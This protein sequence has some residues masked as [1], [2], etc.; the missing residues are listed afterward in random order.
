MDP[1][2]LQESG[3]QV[4]SGNELLFKGALEAGVALMTGYPG[5]PVADFFDGAQAVKDWLNER[6]IVV[7]LAHNEAL[8]V[9]RVNGAQMGNIRA[10]A[11]MK[12]VGAHVASD[13]MA[14]GNLAK[15]G[16]RGGAVVI[17]GDDP[18]SDSTQVP[19]DSRFLSQH[20]HL[21]VMEPATFQ[22]LK[23]W[24]AVAFELS[25]EADC[26]IGY[27]VTTNQADGGGSVEARANRVPAVSRTQRVTLDAGAIPVEDTVLLPPRTGRREAGL[28][29]RMDILLRRAREL[30]VNGILR[31]PTATARVG[32]VTSGLAYCYLEHAL[33][34][35]GVSGRLPILKLGITHPVDATLV[36]E[37][38]ETV[39]ALI[40]VE[41]KR[42]FLETQVTR[43]LKDAFQNGQLPRYISVW[44]KTFPGGRPG[45]PE[46]GGL[47]PSL[48]IE[49]LAP[50]LGLPAFGVEGVDPQRLAAEATLVEATARY[51]VTIP[52]RMPTFCPGC[53]H[54]DSSSVLLDLK[55]DFLNPQYM[56][57][58]HGRGPVDLIFHGD[59]GCYTMYMFEPTKELMH[60]Y[61][62]MGLGGG[63]GAGIDPFITNKQIVFMGDSTFYHSGMLAISDSIQHKQDA[64]Y[65]ILDNKTTAMTGHQP[66]PGQDADIVGRPTFPQ[67]IEAIVTGMTRGG[68][69]PVVRINPAS[70]TGYR[71]CLED[72][73]LQDG[74]KVIIADKECGITY[75]RRVNRER[76]QELNREGFFREELHINID[77]EVCEFC[78]EC[79]RAT[80]CPGLAF[81]DTD[82][83][84]KV[85]IDNSICVE[86]TACSKRKVCPSFEE[87]RVFRRQAPPQKAWPDGR[88]L[89]VPRP[90][91]F[92]ETWSAYVAGVGGMGVGVITATLVRA[93][94]REGLTVRFCDKKG[95]AIRNG[96]VYSHVSF[97]RNGGVR[98]PV[99]P[100]GKVD[101]LL[102]IDLLEAVRGLDPA[103]HFRV[104]SPD[105]TAAVV[106]TAKTATV[107][108]LMGK[109]DFS[110]ADLEHVLQR[111]TKRAAYAGA[112]CAQIAE[113]WLGSKVYANM[114]LLGL[115]CQHGLLPVS[116]ESLEWAITQS[117]RPDD[118]ASNF[119]AFRLGRALVADPEAYL[120]RAL[121]PQS[122]GMLLDDKTQILR[123]RWRGRGLARAYRELVEEA[124]RVMD[125]DD[126][127]ARHL[128]LRV[129]DLVQYE[130]VAYAR[131]YVELVKSVFSKDHPG[132]G[133]R[134][135]KAVIR[136]LHKVMAIKDEVYVAHLLTSEEKRR[137]DL[138]RYDVDPARGDRIEYVHL[139]RPQFTVFGLNAE[140][141]LRTRNWML[142]LMRHAKVLRRLLPGWHARETAFRTWYIELVER[143]HAEDTA[144]YRRYAEA[145]E[146]PETVRGYREVRYPTMAAARQRVAELLRESGGAAPAAEASSLAGV[147]RS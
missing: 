135:T 53:P 43:I 9:A 90:A 74:V 54:R 65:L 21:P 82:F 1:R 88:G 34:E 51:D 67:D 61:S 66:T 79:T 134:A 55:R 6:G 44:G 8:S 136:Y 109:E 119:A 18:W 86:D 2:F 47:N 50:I 15:T 115:A 72:T 95:L 130:D 20:L 24:L 63:T 32:V 93:G 49:R 14:L 26:F 127:T 106:N 75:H 5:S 94:F 128:A 91:A 19:A 89:P 73:I 110:P 107:P 131:R 133:Y 13:G 81:V 71:A 111:Y 60:N 116:L 98:S 112:D 99:V 114:V 87:V 78:L 123:R 29:G 39:E 52:A 45:F 57:E 16:H 124:Q 76:R 139:N 144:A 96:G 125:F 80:G 92:G 105:H 62:G 147:G 41:E 142:R 101:L 97:S 141:D 4:Y 33:L 12:S 100:Y 38:A 46:T 22:E 64:T 31:P 58:R 84:Q 138:E 37:F 28:A 122:Y 59:T 25:Q 3:T 129:Y 118:R 120:P 117:I 126:E 56:Q 48:L 146:A 121:Q 70:R 42:A 85:T 113:T 102:G 108:V 104:A 17:I 103:T 23:D 35:L 132:H 10:L 145:L 137:R 68:A 83:G 69:I 140:W 7:Q 143:F 11:V 77:P 27:L 40:V 30:G 36:R